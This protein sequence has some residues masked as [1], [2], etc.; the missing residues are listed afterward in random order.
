MKPDLA[1]LTK[2]NEA[3]ESLAGMVEFFLEFKCD[4]DPFNMSSAGSLAA[5]SQDENT[6]EFCLIT[7]SSGMK[8]LTQIAMYVVIQMNSQY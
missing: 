1:V 7:G 5:Q 6:Q 3:T 4:V 8:H 2:E